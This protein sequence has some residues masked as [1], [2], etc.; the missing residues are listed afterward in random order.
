MY[1]HPGNPWDLKS[2]KQEPDESLRD[3][4]RRSRQCNSLPNVVDADI[5]GAFLTVITCKSLL[6]K[7]GCRKPRTACELLDITTNHASSEEA[8]GVVFTDG[9]TIGKAKRAE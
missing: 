4:I 5:V 7:L 1:V 9:Q 2:C 3:Y 6:H 8:V